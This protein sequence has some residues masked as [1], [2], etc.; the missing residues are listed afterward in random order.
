VQLTISD[1]A[2]VLLVGPAGA[3]KSTFADTHFART[4]IVSSDAIRAALTDDAGDQ[5]AS[6]EAFQVLAIIV[7]GRLRRRLTTVVDATNLRAANRRRYH[8]LAARYGIPTVVIAFDLA[9]AEYRARNAAR[10]DRLVEEFVVDD[11]A[12]RMAEVLADLP[13]EG[14]SAVHVV[15]TEKERDLVLVRER[16]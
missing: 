14:Y 16:R 5:Q 10:P 3:G 1:P 11:Q 2:L 15:T 9:P 8:R 7:N 6:A 13:G 12:A 4:E